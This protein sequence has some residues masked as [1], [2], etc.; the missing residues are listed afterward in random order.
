VLACGHVLDLVRGEVLS[1]REGFQIVCEHGTRTVVPGTYRMP[2]VPKCSAG[3]FAAPEM[4]LIDLFIGAEGTLGIIVEATLRAQAA[5]PAVALALVPVASDAA[6]VR[7]V[8][9]LRHASQNT[10][11]SRDA[12]G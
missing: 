5:P 3:Y 6:A 2:A 11:H 7:L 1:A 8:A 4:D 9:D 12:R 10:W